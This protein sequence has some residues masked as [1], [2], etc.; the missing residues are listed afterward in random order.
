MDEGKI[1]GKGICFPPHIGPEGRI[2]WS[3][4]AQNIRESIRIILLTEFEERLMLPEF[5]GGLLSFLFEP[6]TASTLRLIQERITQALGR[7]EP[8]IKIESVI[9]KKDPNDEQSALVTIEYKLIATEAGDQ[10]NLTIKLKG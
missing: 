2:A 8:R 4:G 9:V 7:W 10:A 5:G 3:M 1:F 6:N